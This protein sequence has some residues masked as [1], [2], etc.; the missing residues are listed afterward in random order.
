[1]VTKQTYFDKA[2]QIDDIL[3]MIAFYRRQ[4]FNRGDRL[5][6]E[7]IQKF[8]NAIEEIVSESDFFNRFGTI[9][10][11]ESILVTLQG[12]MDAQSQKDY[13]LLADLLELQMLPF[14]F[15]LQDA[16]RQQTDTPITR[17]L[18]DA[19][20]AYAKE[21]LPALAKVME[22][23]SKDSFIFQI[24]DTSQGTVTLKASSE[25]TT[26]YLHSNYAP[27]EEAITLIDQYYQEELTQ[28]VVYGFGLGYHV[29]ELAKRCE[30]M[31]EIYVFESNAAVL[32]EAFHIT[33]IKW[34]NENHVHLFYDPKLEEMSR[35]MEQFPD[36]I[37][38]HY[39]SIRLIRN[40]AIREK[41][42]NLFIQDSSIRN[43]LPDMNRNFR[44]NTKICTHYV[45]E[46]EE[47]W[48]GKN[49]FIVAAGPSL[50]QN[51]ELLRNLPPDSLIVAVGTAYRKLMH[52]RHIKPD[53]VVFL[54]CAM[55]MIAQVRGLHEA[56]IPFLVVSSSS[57]SVTMS[58]NGEK[59]LIC[60]KDYPKA[61]EYARQHAYK[62]YETGGSVSTV[63]FDVALRLG[64]KRIICLG[65][66]L[67]YSQNKM[68]AAATAKVE[69]D[70]TKGLI[71]TED[72]NGGKV[73]TVQPFIMYK[74]WFEER[75][76]NMKNVNQE[77]EQHTE[78]I[79]ATQG[80]VRIQGME[81]CTLERAIERIREAEE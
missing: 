7:W 36:G 41:M 11:Q 19:N 2:D 40:E 67:A 73:Y 47:H 58:C 75:I 65:L 13:V 76:R 43:Q 27:H 18:W 72:L 25:N 46:L 16:I 17:D 5:F 42:M 52:E 23:K 4:N 77:S 8:A 6:A 37:I 26:F 30:G 14:L 10:D 48:K 1:M 62:L 3:R 50:D 56:G 74:E 38:L 35:Y 69:I 33:G 39:P 59:Y 49:I 15:A 9:V 71:E 51:I 22:E 24:E 60:Q 57:R 81:H 29:V 63:A 20:L 12:I 28:Y 78:L 70:D 53:Y 31:A 64:A 79:N 55:R 68:H 80:G 21:Q 45:D 44:I 32:R 34:L 66:D 54:D 61:E